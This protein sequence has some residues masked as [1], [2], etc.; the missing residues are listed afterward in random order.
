MLPQ[1]SRL[2]IRLEPQPTSVDRHVLQQTRAS[3]SGSGEHGYLDV[4]TPYAA[5][6]SSVGGVPRI[7]RRQKI[8]STRICCADADDM[9]SNRAIATTTL[10]ST[11]AQVSIF[12]SDL[13]NRPKPLTGYCRPGNEGLR[14]T[15]HVW[16]PRMS[17]AGRIAKYSRTSHGLWGSALRVV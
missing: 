12:S 10:I 13:R 9:C 17:H 3:A 8:E 16:R 11:R 6:S 1:S 2:M 4:C 14:R 7:I 15:A 5:L